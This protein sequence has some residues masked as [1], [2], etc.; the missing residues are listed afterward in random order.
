MGYPKQVHEKAWQQMIAR[1]NTARET[2]VVHRA[3]VMAKIPAVVEIERRMAGTAAMITKS[4][5]AAPQKAAVL[6]EELAGENAYLQKQREKLLVDAGFPPDYLAEK[7]FCARCGDSGYIG[8]QMC[9]CLASLLRAQ[10][11]AHLSMSAQA[12]DRSFAGFDLSL[13]PREAEAGT[14]VSPQ[15]RMREIYDFCVEYADGFTQDSDSLL[16]LGQTGL[17]KTHLSL[18]IAQCVTEKGFGVLYTPA[19]RLMD[20]LESE[21]F[22]KAPEDRENYVDNMNIVLTCD[23]LILDDLGTEF[24][25]S[26]TAS[27]LYNIVNTRIVEKR[28]TIM[29]TNLDPQ[30]I[31]KRYSQRMVSRLLC[32]YR[33][34]KFFGKD[35]R[36]IKKMQGL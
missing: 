17:G 25:T 8:T 10:A 35:I 30:G 24:A 15:A 11:H 4:V 26:F 21:K 20:R 34:L 33:V 23:L 19:Q 5:V 29:S 7:P 16:F 1:K 28:P 14:G 6:I 3:E 36:F 2:A 12:G 9:D 13:Y 32:E 22:G 31:E 18:A 27:T